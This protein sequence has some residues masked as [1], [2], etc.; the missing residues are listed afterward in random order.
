M[1]SMEINETVKVRFGGRPDD[2]AVDL[3]TG[4]SQMFCAFYAREPRLAE[5]FKVCCATLFAEDS[6]VW[7]PNRNVAVIIAPMK[8]KEENGNGNP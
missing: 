7:D 4:V 5:A 1:V 6:P 2:V 3:A 8:Q